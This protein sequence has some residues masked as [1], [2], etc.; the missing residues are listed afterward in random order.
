MGADIDRAL[1]YLGF[2]R[3]DRDNAAVGAMISLNWQKAERLSN[4]AFDNELRYQTRSRA[5]LV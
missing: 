2:Q 3:Y 1:R 4:S 5:G